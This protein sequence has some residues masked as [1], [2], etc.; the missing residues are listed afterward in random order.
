MRCAAHCR[1]AVGLRSRL[2]RYQ[3]PQPLSPRRG[4]RR[5]LVPQHWQSGSAAE[6]R[7]YSHSAQRRRQ[8]GA[9]SDRHWQYRLL[10]RR[11][12]VRFRARSL[13]PAGPGSVAAVIGFF[14]ETFV[15]GGETPYEDFIVWNFDQGAA[16]PSETA[17][18]GVPT[19][20][21]TVALPP[22]DTPTPAVGLPTETPIAGLPTETPAVGLPTET[23]IAG[24]T[25]VVEPTTAAGT[26]SVVGNTY[27]SPTFGYQL[28]WDPTWSVVTERRKTSSMCCAS[29]M[30]WSRPICIA[31]ELDVAGGMHHLAGRL[32]QRQRVVCERRARYLRRRSANSDAGQCRHCDPDLRLHR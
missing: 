16:T 30:A 5:A 14:N 19:T 17:V 18:V 22:V 25:A 24:T 6:W 13:G 29:P 12:H 27:T 31:G 11:W 20:A 8:G 3:L 23:P 10:R 1:R 4:V 28:T 9:R 7:R 15:P 32:L 21:P 2:P 26:T